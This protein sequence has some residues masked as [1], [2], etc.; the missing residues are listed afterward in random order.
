MLFPNF[1]AHPNIRLFITQCGL[2]S[3]QEAVHH[4]VPLLGIPFFSDQKFNARKI[5]DTGMG[6]QLAFKEITKEL[7]LNAINE[8]LKNT[9]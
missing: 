2:Q 4:G 8:I 3:F 5:Q 1:P 9:R 6:L 7:L